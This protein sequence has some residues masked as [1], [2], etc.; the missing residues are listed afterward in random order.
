MTK[1]IMLVAASDSV[2][3]TK[4]AADWGGECTYVCMACRTLTDSHPSRCQPEMTLPAWHML[5]LPSVMNLHRI[6]QTQHW[7]LRVQNPKW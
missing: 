2:T 5:F 1:I 4:D 6:S 3:D 7:M